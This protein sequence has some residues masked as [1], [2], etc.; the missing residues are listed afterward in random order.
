MDGIRVILEPAYR[1]Q[2]IENSFSAVFVAFWPVL[3][4]REGII[5]YGLI[6]KTHI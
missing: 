3:R 1:H 2:S 6:K 4:F 5:L